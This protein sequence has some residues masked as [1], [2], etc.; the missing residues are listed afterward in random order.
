MLTHG[1]TQ[2]GRRLAKLLAGRGGHRRSFHVHLD[3]LRFGFFPLWHRQGEHAVLVLGLDGLAIHGVRQ[4]EAAAERTIGAL[5]AQI[6][7]L[8]HFLLEFALTANGKDVVLDPDVELLGL[9]VRKVRFYYQCL[10]G[11]KDVY[12]R[13]PS[14]KTGLF[15]G[16]IESLMEE[17]IDLV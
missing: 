5:D 6:I 16:M 9:N 13:S 10:L 4:R 15:R 14:R 1:A 11:L 7:L 17:A 2:R 8:F 12:R 3:L